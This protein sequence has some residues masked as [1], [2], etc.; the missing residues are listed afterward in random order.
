MQ[1]DVTTSDTNRSCILHTLPNQVHLPDAQQAKHWDTEVCSKERVYSRGSQGR[2]WENRSQTH[3]SESERAGYLLGIKPRRGEH[4]ERWLEIRKRWVIIILRR[5][6]YA[7]GFFLARMHRTSTTTPP[8]PHHHPPDNVLTV[9][10]LARW[11][12]RSQSGHSRMP[13]WRVYGP[14]QS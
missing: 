5:L 8:P 12:Q 11:R 1:Y 9:E 6:N 7:T 3:L 4:G 14:N 2:R 10:L 13:S